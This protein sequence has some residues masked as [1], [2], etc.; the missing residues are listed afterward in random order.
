MNNYNVLSAKMFSWLQKGSSGIDGSAKNTTSSTKLNLKFFM[1]M[2]L[3]MLSFG[4]RSVA[5]T[6]FTESFEGTWYLN[7]NSSTAAIAAGPNA[8]SGWTQTRTV[9]NV[10][11][12]GNGSGTHDWAMSTYSGGAYSSSSTPFAAQAPYLNNNPGSPVN[13]TGVLWFYDGNTPSG[14]TRIMGSPAINLASA[15]APVV[16]FSYSYANS[17]T[18]LTLVGSLDGGVT[19]TSLSALPL[20]SS[21][22]WVTKVVTLPLTYRIASAKI[23]FQM[24]STYGSY[25]VFID[26][27]LVK[28]PVTP[29]APLT[30]SATAVTQTSMTIGW[31][32]NSTNENGFRVYRSTDN[33][34]FAQIGADIAST[35][36][37]A[38]G[39][40]YTSAQTG[41]VP[42][43]TYYY[44]I[45]SFVEGEA[46]LLGTQATLAPVAPSCVS[47]PFPADAATGV[48]STPT[49][50]WIGNGLPAPTY[51]VYFGLSSALVTAKNAT[52]K[53]VAASA[54]ASYAPAA[55]TL[56]STYYW[57]VVPSNVGGGPTS[58]SVFSF[59]VV[60]PA[61]FTAT[62]NGGLWNSAATWVGGIVPPAGNDI[63]IPAGSV[64]TANQITNYRNVT[65]NG[66]LQWGATSYAM[67][68]TS[69]LLINSG[70]KFLPYSTTQVGQVLNIAGNF[71]NDGY[72]NLSLGT[73]ALTFN[74]TTGSTLSGTG[75]FQ[76]NGTNGIIRSL[77]FSSLGGGTVSTSQNLVITNTLAHSAG[78]LNT[79]G[80]LILDNTA[81][82]Y[83]LALNNQVANVV[84]TAMNTSSYSVNP[85]VFG[86][87]VTQWTNITGGLNTL[88]V[89]GN[90]VYRCSTAANIGPSAPTHTSGI[91]QNLLWVGTV[92]TI[93]TP[94][95]GA[96]AHVLGTQYFYGNNL[97]TCT[98]AGTASTTAPPVHT[99]GV[100][101][102]GTASFL[103]VGSPAT[104]SNNFDATT[105]TVRSLNLVS[106]GS[107]YSITAPAIAFSIGAVGATGAGAAATAV[108]IQQ[109]AGAASHTLQKGG[110]AATISGGLTI[111]SDQG[112][113]VATSY[114][115]ASS[116]VGALSTTNG[117]NNY[118]VAPTVGFSGPT[119]LNLVTNGGSG[120]TTAPTITVTGG[121]LVSGTALATGNF[122][123]TVNG[124]LVESVY[125]TGTATY[126]V[127]P[128][129]AFTGGAGTGATLAFPTGCWPT[130][131]ASIGANGQLSNFTVTNAGFGYNVAPTVGVGTTSGNA[132]GGTFTTV[133]TAPTARIGLYNVTLN[134]F[135]PATVA[136]VNSDDAAFPTNRKLNNLSLAGNGLGLNLTSGLT[137]YGTAPLTLTASSSST[138]NVL[139]LGG[140]NLNCTWSS[141]A[142]ATS[143]FGATN[144]YIKNGSM[145]LT[146]RG[147]GNTGSTFNFPFSGTVNVFTGT[148]STVVNGTNIVTVKVS[149]TAAP[150]NTSN[151]TAVASGTRAYKVE[152]ATVLGAAALVGTNPTVTLNYNSMDA[153]T[154]TQDQTFV[155][156]ST[157][158]AGPWDLKSTAIGASGA[159]AA[160]GSKATA[161]VAPGPI[162]LVSG[163]YYSWAGATPT[164]TDVTP[165]SVCANSGTFTITGT[166]FTG[167][168]A[169]KIG[170]T[171]VT[172]FTVVSATSI[173][174]YAGNGTDGVVSIV[175]NNGTVSG[176]QTVTFSPSPSAPSVS[177]AAPSIVLGASTSLTAT[178]TGGT[179]NW[180][181]TATGGSPVY[182]G[183]TYSLNGICSTTTYYVAE[184]N[185]SCDGARQAVTVTVQPTIITPSVATF[186]GTGGNTV[187]TV[188][189]ADPSITYT[190]TALTSGATL[191]ATTGTSVT[192]TLSATSDF[193]VVATSGACSATAY[194][195]V[196]VYALPTA[197]VTTSASGVCPG[198]AATI[199]SGLS[200]GNFT[201]TSIPYNAITAPVAA[202]TIVT[203]G[204]AVVPLS[205]GSLDDG[206][207]SGIP[208]GFN[209]NFFGT[210]FNT[211]SAGTNGLLM[212]GPVPGYGTSAGQLGQYSFN[213]TGGVF[214]NVN[215][216][217]NVIALMAADQYFGSGTAASASGTIKY[218][219]Q[220]YAPNRVFVIEY[221]DVDACC[222]NLATGFT[223]QARLYETLG[224]VDI[225]IVSKT[226]T[227]AS[228]VGL[229]NGDKTIGAVAPGRQA[230]TS[231]FTTPESWR[232]SPPSNY[233]TVW[234]KTDSSGT[235]TIASGTNIFSQN[236]APLVTT[237]Y[238][239]SYTNQTTGC[240]NA[241]GSAQVTMNVLSN[242][243][244]SGVTALASPSTLCAGSNVNLYTDYTGATAG[245][246][247][248]WQVS[249]N[250]TTWN[251]ISGA[252]GPNYAEVML[253]PSQYRVAITSCTGS[254]VTS[255]PVSVTFTNN[256]DSTTP[257]TRCGTGSITLNATT[258]SAG[259][260]VNWYAAAT[261]GTALYTGAAYTIPFLTATTTYYV[262]A[263]TAGC[264][265]PR[266]AVTA[267]QTP[268]PT[269]TLSASTV[270]ICTGTSSSAVTILAGG[271]PTFD[272][273]T[274]SPATGVSGDAATGWIFNPSV[275]TVYT[276]NATQT[277]GQLCST[278]TT[279]S[280]TVNSTN[281]S[282]STNLSTICVNT[283]ANL[284]ATSLALG[285]GPQIAPSG[286]LASNSTI[287]ADEDILNVTFGTLN[288]TSTCTSTG[289][290]SSILSEYSDFTGLTPP[291]II[292]GT[293]MPIS[294]GVGTCG[295]FNYSNY[296]NVYIDYNRNGLF[297]STEHV[298]QSTASTSG[299][300]LESGSFTIPATAS[301]G[302][303]RMRVYV[304][305]GGSAT[306]GPETTYS[307]GETEDY[308]VNI[309]SNSDVTSTYT[310]SWSPA[311]SLATSNTAN[312]VASPMVTTTYTVTATNPATGCTK[313]A[314]VTVNVISDPVP[315]IVSTSN[316]MCL[317]GSTNSFTT[318][319]YSA[320]VS[321]VSTNPAVA[322]VDANGTVTAVSVGTAVIKARI[323]N[324]LTGCTSY[325]ANP[326]TVNVY[327]P[328][329]ITSNP[330]S[331]SVVTASPAT[332]TVGATGSIV[333][334][335]WKVSTTGGVGTF[336]NLANNSVYSGVTTATLSVAT[337]T[338]GGVYYYV[339]E[340]TGNSPCTSPLTTT[341]TNL[342]VASVAITN[343]SPATICTSG[344]G[345]ATFNVTT[346]GATPDQ[347]VWELFT[348]A[349]DWITL[350]SSATGTLGTVT[351][352]GDTTTALTLSGLGLINTGWMVRANAY[353]AGPPEVLVTSASAL[354]TVNAPAV[355]T[356]NPI[357]KTVCYSGGTSTFTTVATGAVSYQ[358]QYSTNGTT[359]NNVVNATPA[360]TTYTNAT[361]ATLSVAT[362]IATP[363]IGTYYYR[364]QAISPASCGN[365]VSASAQLII[366]TPAI[367]A[368]TSS[369]LYCSPNGATATLTATGGVSYTWSPATGLS[370]TTGATVVANPSA[371]TTYTVTGT[372]ALGCSKTA[373]VTVNVSSSV[374]GDAY[375]SVTTVCP[376]AP[377]T[378]SANASTISTGPQVEPSGY[379][380]S[381]ATSLADEEI[382]NVTFGS[383]NN[384]ST[385]TTTGG[386]SSIL[387]E[388]SDFT[389]LTP[390]TI[391]AGTI[392]PISVQVGTCGGNYSNYT[393]VYIDYNR[394]GLFEASEHAYQ[395]TASVSG[396]HLETGSITIPA[397][398]LGGVTRM[399]VYVI[400]GGSATSSPEANYTWGETEDYDVN[401]LG[402]STSGLTYS[403]SN[404]TSVVSTVENP[405]VN[406]AVTTTYSV[407]TT[408]LAGCSRTSSVT[409]N[410]VSGSAITSQ[411]VATTVCQ[412]GTATFSVVGTGPGLT[413]Q[414]YKGTTAITTNAT[415]FTASLTITGTVIAD[416][417]NYY[418]VVT[419]T[420]G[421]ATTSNSVALLV[422]PTPVAT[423]LTNKSVCY[424][425]ATAPI[426]L[427]GTPFG[428]TFDVTGGTSIG[429]ANQ[430]GVTSIPSFTSIVGSA[431]IT[432]TPKANGCSGLPITF[433]YT[434]NAL[435]T[436][437][438][439][440]PAA[441][442][443]CANGSPVLLTVTG[444]STSQAYCTPAMTSASASGDYINNF[445]FAN[446]TNNNSGD[447]ASDY[448]YYSGLTAN[449]VAG[450]T[451]NISFA[452]ST[453][454]TNQFRAWIDFNQDGV[455]QTSESVY[456]SVTGSSATIT[457]TATI[458]SSA[459]NGVTRLRVAERYSTAVGAAAS[460]VGESTFGEYEDYNVSI[461]GG[462]DP[463]AVWASSTGN[464]FTNAAGT[465]AY[466]GT[467]PRF[468]IYARPTVTSTISATVT[469]T[470]GCSTTGSTVITVN[471]VP[472][473][474][475]SG[476]TATCQNST[477]PFVTF[478]GAN[479]TAPYTFT[480]KIGSGANQT[481]TTTS[482]NSVTVAAPTT[483]TGSFVYTLVSVQDSSS[484]TCSQTQT[485]S[486]TITINVNVTYYADA[487]HDGYGNPGAPQVSCFGVP[488]G[489]VSNN[490]DCD[491][492]RANTH[493]GAAEVCYDGVDNDCNGNIDNVGM[494]GGC[495]PIVSNVIPAQCGVTLGLL[496]D[497]V[498]AVLVANAQGYRWRI[499]KMVAGV[500]S[501]LPAD[502][503]TLDTGLRSFKFTQL[504]SYAFDTTYQIE[505]SVRLNSVWQPFYGSAC[506]VSTPTATS[507]VLTTQCGTTLLSMTDVVYAN[508]VSYVTG[509]RF[510][511][512]NLLTSNVQ[513]LDRSV[514]EFR[515]NLLSNI[516]YNTAYKIEVAV[517]NT[518]GVYMPYGPSCNIN[519]PLFPTTSLQDSQCDYTAASNTEMIYAKLVANATNYRFS[520]TNANIG[521]GYVF[522]TTL[523]AFALNTV[524]GLLPSTIYS[525]KVMVKIDGTWGPYGKICTLTTPGT[526]RAIVSTQKMETLF[527]ATAYPN[528]FAENF[529][530]D[531]KT[532][533]EEALQVKVY[534]MLG[535]LIDN[536]ILDATQVEGFEVGSA[537]PTGVYN[538]IVSQGENV[539][540]LRVI[541]R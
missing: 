317:G 437:V 280:V 10:A 146:G 344:S 382:L 532:S 421:A 311:A 9:N 315:D 65:I 106:A 456:A 481:V 358:W 89:S 522:D 410:V 308:N 429:L 276:L 163:N 58:C 333:S 313:T 281:V 96:Q 130:A 31:V 80:K 103:Y 323:V 36:V 24:S 70:G 179:M 508:L 419:P 140:N 339:C 369:S 399:R 234:T 2:L 360:G 340:I 243:A 512:T 84:V 33:I 145:T 12:S 74:G 48:T 301:A 199:N 8:P 182:T 510:K 531:I 363:G 269:L 109:V 392:V 473:A 240:A 381:N 129:L 54:T 168:T 521:Y 294:I 275:S 460:C 300:H 352:S 205:G 175:K 284:S 424:G 34:T 287:A 514:R 325:A 92:G 428:V 509:Y 285:S 490:T 186:C 464:L 474:T 113:S 448:T 238:N 100:V 215:N 176:T 444:G 404:G 87:A 365:P 29:N 337:A 78:T 200:A 208:I 366:N 44:K 158:L 383:I 326:Q 17:S 188:S 513:Y 237:V 405:V 245:L 354:I 32:D 484:T 330:T 180:Y 190:W 355:I 318:S 376:N 331:L 310:Y 359:W 259:A 212:F 385:C 270:A 272:N 236:V 356:A 505:V 91:S 297:E 198:T 55:L 214:P 263:E 449:V 77:L 171:P 157:A 241:V 485:G 273:Y 479:G 13:G 144:T 371:T 374:F 442:S 466:N 471:P 477:S 47:T 149:D 486:A 66:T 28:E 447:T 134:F 418:V 436:A 286:Y 257:A 128:T 511:I 160:T 27:L 62:A 71:Q 127:P 83:G 380:A 386:G 537:Y 151:G 67:N 239:I 298:Y 119:T 409:V 125:L 7:G 266:V 431:T 88:Y 79:G 441:I 136:V 222:S 102:S 63:T 407:T 517:R 539:K 348:P 327:A 526:G 515:F 223:A 293:T 461:T 328:L 394:N 201:V 90:N 292:A 132:I 139:D 420:C 114:P 64:V 498:L 414:W 384:S 288:N 400:E 30:F 496:D 211:I 458:P 309:L 56:G 507:K 520:V 143:T 353:V 303:T 338:L 121:T 231:T 69:N 51:D 262:A 247:Y 538:V 518:N 184:N 248:Q 170:G 427:T 152:T 530:L 415:A 519:T 489:Y 45:V 457:G 195:S 126:S 492:T 206:G 25:D 122:T 469:N 307:Y 156:E 232:F 14:T 408:S 42:G 244:P 52:V 304:V 351:F 433:V 203:N 357:D 224:M 342:S 11:P 57:M 218:W 18:A 39:G 350:D 379:L 455:F 264:S 295:S 246:S 60:A 500:P 209:F 497:Q 235:S 341:V 177:P 475:I 372:D 142:G 388:Y 3:L 167:V 345:S 279:V 43:T 502:I 413:Y 194:Y 411:P 81:Q 59:T 488:S 217:G 147:G 494:P 416:S 38:T 105:G 422:N 480:Y 73:T 23:G 434:I 68:L 225:A 131:T 271:L 233:T 148:G 282:A 210:S 453:S 316:V 260:T 329:A 396:P 41:L 402:M 312:V 61:G 197:T 423:A 252:T 150:S 193:R 290:G 228:T 196:G 135:S 332:F 251:N 524:P 403:W 314:D 4:Q 98:A 321:W 95:L 324:T 368:S 506:T 367:T 174:G 265:S 229:Q 302:V 478:T 261:G 525:V 20:T 185:G 189:P 462:L 256:I 165:L 467:S 159:L 172:S 393:N 541:K 391:T 336:T 440:T 362:T 216:P 463:G 207:W 230:F 187:L 112:A 439:I 21:T 133:A 349:T 154:S 46:A 401:I 291:T 430:T 117:G 476:T 487:D 118:T 137:L 451:Y 417:A 516:P 482:G 389:S 220:G 258:S 347:I 164:I 299:A 99:T 85:V 529:K 454:W 395:S 76:G 107:G 504:A 16:S 173:T 50:T 138:G 470:A 373:T 390:P 120:Y 335:Q 493:P 15:T 153:L 93:G 343:P 412:G 534:D 370:S 110:G 535:K 277:S 115:Q 523:R 192:A 501:T 104:V 161:T 94:F 320:A 5:Q 255:A 183:L 398:A 425:V 445:S 435:P 75:V 6:Y 191:D 111:N 305:E 528:P 540:T 35:T 387:N 166:N 86:A 527:D 1:F 141:Y 254:P 124:G 249:T 268:P 213:S 227:A 483:A 289:G 82:V 267:T 446:I 202:T 162:A 459:L 274:W 364:V 468:T 108:L 397:N 533:S 503:Q 322:T 40:A 53:V 499:T 37:A 219:T 72:A 226:G 306:S 426:T 450:S 377:V 491:D 283:S 101:A 406:P 169:V 26:N 361:T 204:A 452:G 221:S 250:G 22:S 443:N 472:T 296:T 242:T 375:A 346:S 438:T 123:I 495:T 116:G 155:A 49:L 334:Y 319:P 19:W 97:Y 278:F 465:T 253:V 378:L 181:T 432:V 536:R 178:G